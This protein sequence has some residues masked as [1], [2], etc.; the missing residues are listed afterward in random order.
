M[1]QYVPYKIFVYGSYVNELA[2]RL[3][4]GIE[5]DDDGNLKE[6]GGFVRNP[7]WTISL[8][9]SG[10]LLRWLRIHAGAGMFDLAQDTSPE[11]KLYERRVLECLN[12]ICKRTC[13]QRL[14]QGMDPSM[15]VFIVRHNSLDDLKSGTCNASSNGHKFGG[16]VRVAFSPDAECASE[17]SSLD[18]TLFHELFHSYIST[19]NLDGGEL[20][21][22]M[23]ESKT[24]EEFLA[25]QV[26]NM[27]QAEKGGRIFQRVYGGG[28]GRIKPPVAVN[29]DQL[30]A[31][32][33]SDADVL[34]TLGMDIP[35]LKDLAAQRGLPLNPFRDLGLYQARFLQNSR[36]GAAAAAGGGRR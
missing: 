14:L 34:K 17:Y 2:F 16:N 27:Y 26:T 28:S 29:K 23:E 9:E 19:N 12:Q 1:F 31:Y 18:D 10:K 11:A 13:G 36:K 6:V 24:R 4:G 21:D 25:V 20:Y 3:L 15:S 5:K 8:K 33:S 7:D 35:L 32:L 30:E 22:Q